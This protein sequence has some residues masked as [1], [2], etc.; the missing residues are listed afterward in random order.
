MPTKSREPQTPRGEPPAD[1]DAG[2][3][4]SRPRLGNALAAL[5]AELRRDLADGAYHP[6]E[7]LVE[8]DLVDRYDTSRGAVRE[9]LI[10]LTAEGLLERTPNRGARV[11][12][13]TLEEAVEIAEVR[14]AI[15]TLCA[16]R[17]AERAT[18]AERRLLRSMAKRMRDAANANRV[19]E[20]LRINSTFHNE[21]YGMSRHATAAAI[22][23]QIQRRPIDRFFPVPFRA[24]PPTASIDDHERIAQAIAD[25][26]VEAAGSAMYEHLTG[27][28]E[29]LR[30][31]TPR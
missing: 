2:G 5:L 23:E 16:A 12:A 22:L 4:A 11:R 25:G 15:E 31:P 13:M 27:L 19:D 21:V 9:A 20:Y 14:R 17:A 8:A 26:D 30:P 7:R 24:R 6:R 3:D 29:V 1:T 18:A 10:Q 28:V